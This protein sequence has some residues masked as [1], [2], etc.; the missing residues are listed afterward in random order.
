M[1][2][3]LYCDPYDVAIASDAS[4]FCSRQTL[5]VRGGPGPAGI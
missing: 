4:S 2:A 5:Y 1:M 3:D